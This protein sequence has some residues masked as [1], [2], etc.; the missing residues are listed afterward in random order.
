[1][2]RQVW[3]RGRADSKGALERPTDEQIAL[4]PHQAV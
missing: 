4:V 2:P 1:M 3:V